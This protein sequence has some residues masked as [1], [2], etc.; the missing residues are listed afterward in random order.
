M[1]CE[2]QGCWFWKKKMLQMLC[3]CCQMSPQPQIWELAADR[4]NAHVV[5]CMCVQV[6][7]QCK[8]R[9]MQ[10]KCMCDYTTAGCSY[11]QSDPSKKQRLDATA[12]CMMQKVQCV[13]KHAVGPQTLMSGPM[14]APTE[15]S[16][17]YDQEQCDTKR[18]KCAKCDGRECRT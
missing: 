1:L 10:I 11:D 16:A 18:A 8:I 14:S 2:M 17:T 3:E 9:R 13:R 7:M 5:Q 15:H 4:C 6:R 12:E